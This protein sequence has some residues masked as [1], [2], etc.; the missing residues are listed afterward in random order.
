MSTASRNC[1]NHQQ[2][3]RVLGFNAPHI[4]GSFGSGPWA[5]RPKRLQWLSNIRSEFKIAALCSSVSSLKA[6]TLPIISICGL[7]IGGGHPLHSLIMRKRR[8]ERDGSG[9]F[10]T[11]PS[12]WLADGRLGV[13][14]RS[15]IQLPS[16]VR[17]LGEGAQRA[18]EGSLVP[19]NG[20]QGPSSGLRPPSPIPMGQEKAQY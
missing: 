7:E 10:G 6:N 11:P 2:R 19:Q 5:P 20:K 16:P 12:L 9:D 17:S 1:R 8:P 13:I 14:G 3:L 15:S 4:L 18:G